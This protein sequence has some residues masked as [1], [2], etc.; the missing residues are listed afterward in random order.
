MA[1]ELTTEDI[2]KLGLNS[3]IQ[4]GKDFGFTDFTKSSAF[5]LKN[6]Y[7]DLENL[8]P[9]KY[10]N[11]R[12]VV[13]KPVNG[14]VGPSS[15]SQVWLSWR[16]VIE[17]EH[18]FAKYNISTTLVGQLA[19][20]HFPDEYYAYQDN[21]FFKP[22][23]EEKVVKRVRDNNNFP[24]ARF[25][26]P[27][28]S[29]NTT[30]I[31]ITT[32]SGEQNLRPKF[33]GIISKEEG[34]KN[35][36]RWY[37][38]ATQFAKDQSQSEYDGL[39]LSGYNI[40]YPNTL[41]IYEGCPL[42]IPTKI[43][44]KFNIENTQS[45]NGLL[46]ISTGDAEEKT[47]CYVSPH[48]LSTGH[49]N[50]IE[51]IYTEEKKE[52]KVTSPGSE[53]LLTVERGSWYGSSQTGYIGCFKTGYID[54]LNGTYREAS[55]PSINKTHKRFYKVGDIKKQI[56]FNP[57][58]PTLYGSGRW[59]MA[60]SGSENIS[61]NSGQ[62]AVIYVHQPNSRSDW[63]KKDPRTLSGP[64][65][66]ASGIANAANELFLNRAGIS[67]PIVSK[68][69]Q[70]RSTRTISTKRLQLPSLNI[71]SKYLNNGKVLP[72]GI[73]RIT[74]TYTDS[75]YPKWRYTSIPTG[76]F[77]ITGLQ[78]NPEGIEFSGYII[79]GKAITMEQILESGIEIPQIEYS[80]TRY[81]IAEN[82][83][84]AQTVPL[85]DTYFYKFYNQLY[86]RNNK[87][88][89]TGTWDGI[90]PSGVRFSVELV[91]NTLNE[92]A[93]IKNGENIAV[94][95]AQ[96]GNEDEIDIAL[97]TGISQNGAHTIYPNPSEKYM[98]SGQV[99]WHQKRSPYR[100]AFNDFGQLSYTAFKS[101]PT[102]TD[103]VNIAK[104]AA[105]TKIN[106]KLLQL[107]NKIF[108]DLTYKNKKWRSLQKFKQKINTLKQRTFS[109]ISVPETTDPT[110][111][112]QTRLSRFSSNN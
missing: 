96:Y 15:S 98:V 82:G 5:V 21:N 18:Y 23:K 68:Y 103:A 75:I 24:Y 47:I 19:D 41:S 86:G 49:L 39:N 12:L 10:S 79:S 66:V 56:Y 91:S 54:N 112:T 84:F 94:I 87:T 28:E 50:T 35:Y 46:I 55:I 16:Q 89:A 83:H 93:G 45:L 44:P 61:V 73:K 7:L 36:Y 88:I 71:D 101:G 105:I 64:W 110:V 38:Q 78:Y 33:P 85:K 95:Y 6:A 17:Q 14:S 48:T 2:Q 11:P 63:K 57:T 4:A 52:I 27:K 3:T 30:H 9:L 70:C 8:G 65:V 29:S 102:E 77:N 81:S 107:V 100:H 62:Q 40:P 76:D 72:E 25:R 111:G 1:I 80:G 108:P 34:R 31:R 59:C 74:Y 92:Y 90:I 67:K 43:A 13:R 37:P 32:S 99:P 22:Y 51:D 60:L 109:H 26:F 53:V 20:V 42:N 97:Q 106:A 104:V 58:L 69:K